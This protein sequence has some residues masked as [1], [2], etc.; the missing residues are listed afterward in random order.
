MENP[1]LDPSR[2]IPKL[3]ERK[4]KDLRSE[5]K[6]LWIRR[7]VVLDKA[8]EDKTM[9][10]MSIWRVHVADET[11]SV[12]LSA[13][14][15]RGKLLCPGDIAEVKFGYSSV[16]G[17]QLR[18]YIGKLGQIIRHGRCLALFSDATNLSQTGSLVEAASGS[19]SMVG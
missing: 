9:D 16:R 6:H 11:A 13:F 14:G 5:E 19:A 10:G 8:P 2:P 1:A 15:D 17:G 12:Y 7:F 3:V 4:I 18:L